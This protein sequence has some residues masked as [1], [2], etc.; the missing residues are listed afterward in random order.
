VSSQPLGFTHG[1]LQTCSPR[2]LSLA[3]RTLPHVPLTW[4]INNHRVERSRGNGLV[5]LNPFAPRQTDL[6]LRS[7]SFLQL[8]W[9][10]PYSSKY[11][12]SWCEYAVWF[13]SSMVALRTVKQMSNFSLPLPLSLSLSLSLSVLAQ[14]MLQL[15]DLQN[16]SKHEELQR[17]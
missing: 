4:L 10:W 16:D 3:F 17:L 9:L 11:V 7:P 6:S 14:R 5:T 15:R 8:K 1:F 13:R 12:T 2:S